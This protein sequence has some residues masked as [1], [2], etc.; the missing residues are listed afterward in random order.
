MWASGAEAHG[1]QSAGLV[2]V[3]HRLSCSTAWGIFPDQGSNPC[4]LHWQ[5]DSL[6]L[7]HPA[8]M[9]LIHFIVQQTLTQHC[10]EITLQFLKNFLKR[11]RSICFQI[12]TTS[13]RLTKKHQ[14]PLYFFLAPSSIILD[15]DPELK[16][17]RLWATSMK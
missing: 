13:I 16:A 8:Y 17:E 11:R 9:Q 3:G 1:L 2:V 4:P 15:K 5:A 12:Q 7:S 10:I 14:I 6:P